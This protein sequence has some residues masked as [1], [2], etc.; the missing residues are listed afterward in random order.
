MNPPKQ[1]SLK[2][3]QQLIEIANDMYKVGTAVIVKDDNGSEFTDTIRY[4]ASLL[5]SHTPVAWLDGA[6]S[7]LLERVLR[8]SK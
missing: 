3:K 5:G 1:K 7:Y 4:P 8:K 6:G 2:Q